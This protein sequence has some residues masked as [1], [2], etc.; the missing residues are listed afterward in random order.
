MAPG[1]ASAQRA[2]R[3]GAESHRPAIFVPRGGAARGDGGAAYGRKRGRGA[4]RMAWPRR[5]RG[6]P[7]PA[8]GGRVMARILDLTGLMGAYGTRLLAELGHDVLRIESPKGDNLRREAPLL[9]RAAALDAGA[10]HQ[11]LNAGKRSA[12]IDLATEGGR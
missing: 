9:G 3:G 2:W 5:S 12:A 1:L 4:A 10:F 6:R 8:R 7:A 11:F